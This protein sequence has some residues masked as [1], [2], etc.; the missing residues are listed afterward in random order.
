MIKLTLQIAGNHPSLSEAPGAEVARILRA[1]AD[2]L[3]GT[4]SEPCGMAERLRDRDGHPVGRYAFDVEAP[5]APKIPPA[6]KRSV[7][8]YDLVR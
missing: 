7:P 3:E 4:T 6:P 8:V 2:K 5:P 1:V